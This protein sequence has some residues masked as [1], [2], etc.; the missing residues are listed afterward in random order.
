M[1]TGQD[2]Y[3][4]IY[5]TRMDLL[6]SVERWRTYGI[7][8]AG[9]ERTYRSALCKMIIRLREEKKVPWTACS[10]IA[11]GTDAIKDL[12]FERDVAKIHYDAE[13]E[14]INVL[15]INSRIVENQY[16]EGMRQS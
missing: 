10:D 5:K 13:Q 11:R 9:A 16:K 8:L 3:N 1:H 15:K 7:A 14:V 12:R 2:L 4:A 6:D